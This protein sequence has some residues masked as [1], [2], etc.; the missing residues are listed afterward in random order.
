MDKKITEEIARR[1]EY[2]RKAWVKH[3]AVQYELI[4]DELIG[5][6][7]M[8]YTDLQPRTEYTFRFQDYILT[9]GEVYGPMV[10]FT[11][12]TRVMEFYFGEIIQRTTFIASMVRGQMLSISLT[13][14]PKNGEERTVHMTP[15]EPGLQ[16]YGN[17]HDQYANAQDYVVLVEE[18]MLNGIFVPPQQG[19]VIVDMTGGIERTYYVGAISGTTAWENF[20]IGKPAI[21]IHSKM[22]RKNNG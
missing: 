17:E 8:G 10:V 4:S 22:H 2:R 19:D 1:F 21:V 9:P 7:R 15:L 14:R 6:F 16:G 20:G 18:F 3:N 12:S 11:A 5:S 13:Y